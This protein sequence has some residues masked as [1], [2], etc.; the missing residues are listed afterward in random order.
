M[1]R[2]S[3]L[4][5]GIIFSIA[6]LNAQDN[7]PPQALSYKAVMKKANGAPVHRQ[8]IRLLV[9]IYKNNIDDPDAYIEELTTETDITG[10]IS[11]EIGKGKPLSGTFS[12]IN[13]GDGIFYLNIKVDVEG[14]TNY[15]DLS[16]TQLLSVP[17]AL[18]AGKA[19]PK[20]NKLGDMRYWDGMKWTLLPI[21]TN[22]TTLFLSN[23]VPTWR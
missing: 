6:I 3:I 12:M 16:T 11:I 9:K 7:A 2:I 19:G 5:V 17:Y 10:K 23:G 22:G 14:G 8:V 4:L 18:Y 15:Q 1:K 21:G 20:G 13:W